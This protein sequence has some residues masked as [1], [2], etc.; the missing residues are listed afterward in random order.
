MNWNGRKGAD[1]TDA[2]TPDDTDD[3]EPGWDAIDGALAHLYQTIG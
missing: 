1:M 2:N 3:S